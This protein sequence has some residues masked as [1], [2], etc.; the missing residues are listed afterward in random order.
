MLQ[1]VP[2]V[3]SADVDLT[4]NSATVEV[5]ADVDPSALTKALTGQYSGTVK[6]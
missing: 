6:N 2:G 5:Q 3:K 1:S 4:T